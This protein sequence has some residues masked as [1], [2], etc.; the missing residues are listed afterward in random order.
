MT[1][2]VKVSWS[3]GAENLLLEEGV[4]DMSL[5]LSLWLCSCAAGPVGL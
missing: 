3:G 4:N 5:T 2:D 1:K